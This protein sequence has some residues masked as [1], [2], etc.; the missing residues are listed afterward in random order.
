MKA[1]RWIEGILIGLFIA[2]VA[3]ILSIQIYRSV[4]NAEWYNEKQT[5]K[6]FLQVAE[7]VNDTDQIK[8]IK[9]DDNIEERFVY[10]APAELFDDLAAKS[11][12]HIEDVEKQIEIWTQG[13]VTVFYN[14]GT[15][16][17]FFITDDGEIYWGT[18]LKIEC[19]SLLTWYREIIADGQ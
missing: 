1:K 16:A 11:Y 5:K 4:V 2:I 15:A 17:S 19:P 7:K 9:V 6:K 8:C 13:C 3:S 10:D 14:D 12:E 18:S